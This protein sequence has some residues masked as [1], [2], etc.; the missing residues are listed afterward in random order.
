MRPLGFEPKTFP[1]KAG[2]SA[3]WVT[4]AFLV[5]STHNTLC[6][7]CY[8][9]LY[10]RLYL[11]IIFFISIFLLLKVLSLTYW[12]YNFV[13]RKGIEPNPAFFAQASRGPA[14]S[15]TA[16]IPRYF[17]GGVGVAPTLEQIYCLFE[18]CSFCCKHFLKV[19]MCSFHFN[20]PITHQK[21]TDHYM[22]KTSVNT[23][24]WYLSSRGESNTHPSLGKAP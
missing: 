22:S 12:I 8:Q 6:H 15:L 23:L 21:S 19:K 3:N 20:P 5:I 9:R 10:F 14:V 11:N 13:G 18:F 7:W 1:L 16:Y 17:V 4:S 2:Y 24:L